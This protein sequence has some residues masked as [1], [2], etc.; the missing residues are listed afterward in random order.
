MLL[1]PPVAV[2][3]CAVRLSCQTTREEITLTVSCQ[4]APAV[5]ATA[6]LTNQTAIERAVAVG[7]VLGNGTRR[8]SAIVLRR[9]VA[10]ASQWDD[11]T[12]MLGPV[13]GRVHPWIVSLVPG[14]SYS[15][16]IDLDRFMFRASGKRLDKPEE[17]ALIELMLEAKLVSEEYSDTPAVYAIPVWTGSLTSNSLRIP[18]ECQRR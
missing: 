15:L 3:G 10:N 8:P 17:P 18:D 4:R 13:A 12:Y 11:L 6:T 5:V 1:G 2:L 9:K 7:I 14:G 16:P